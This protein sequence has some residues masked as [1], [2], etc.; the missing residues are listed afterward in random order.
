VIGGGDAPL[1]WFA[2]VRH[3]LRGG[4]WHQPRVTW[5]RP[6]TDA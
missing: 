5:R 3:R 1:R 2:S 6:W 4:L